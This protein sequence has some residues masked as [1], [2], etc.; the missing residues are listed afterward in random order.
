V[1]GLGGELGGRV[2]KEV[3]GDALATCAQADTG[4]FRD[5][6]ANAAFYPAEVGAGG[7]QGGAVIGD[8]DRVV[9]G[10]AHLADHRRILAD[11]QMIVRAAEYGNNRVVVGAHYAMDVLGGRTVAL[12][13]S[14]AA[15]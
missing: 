11:Q 12:Q 5:A 3:C 13:A 1:A 10:P 2:L 7:L 9:G 14:R 4:R 6:T 8:C 15:R